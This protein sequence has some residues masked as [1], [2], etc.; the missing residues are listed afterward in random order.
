MK[1]Q[2][3]LIC[4][5]LLLAPGPWGIALNH[6][7]EECGGYWSGDEYGSFEL[8]EG[9]E[10][11]YPDDH[12]IIQTEIGSCTF[13]AP[14][15]SEGAESCCHELGYTYVG[16]NVGKART[17]PLLLYSLAMYVCRGLAV[18]CAIALAAVLIIGGGFFL[19]KRRRQKQ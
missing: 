16:P 1:R 7:T 2:A 15:S 10:A 3:A 5:C 6:E 12:G 14:R 19:W 17:S 18:L 8:P 13:G 4:L 9:W 11:Y